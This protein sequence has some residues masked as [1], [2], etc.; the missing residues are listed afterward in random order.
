MLSVDLS[1]PLGDEWPFRDDLKRAA[2]SAFKIKG[3]PVVVPTTQKQV[4]SQPVVGP[5]AAS[6]FVSAGAGPS[7]HE[8]S[9]TKGTTP[10]DDTQDPLP[11]FAASNESRNLNA[12]D[13]ESEPV[14]PAAENL[15]NSNMNIQEH[16]LNMI[17]DDSPADTAKKRAI[18]K[19]AKSLAEKQ[20]SETK[21]TVKI[22]PSRKAPST[23]TRS[24]KPSQESQSR[25]PRS[26][27]TKSEKPV[28]KVQAISAETTTL[29][30]Q[31]LR[32]HYWQP[33]KVKEVKSPPNN[34][35]AV[36]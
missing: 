25:K 13:N 32:E 9:I 10:T 24:K 26:T 22:P 31:S 28:S 30:K 23:S 34:K 15:V 5:T 16:L 36:K 35:V 17:M 4:S 18:E 3:L 8:E 12:M 2:G 29:V 27:S 7:E 11:E 33:V 21:I 6:S 1:E 20:S 14:L 19:L